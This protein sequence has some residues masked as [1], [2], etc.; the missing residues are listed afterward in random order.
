VQPDSSTIIVADW[1][2]RD[3]ILYRNELND[4]PEGV[5]SH[6]YCTSFGAACAYC[7]SHGYPLNDNGSVACFVSFDGQNADNVVDG[8]IIRR[9]SSAMNVCG[10]YVMP[11]FWIDVRNNSAEQMRGG[12]YG[13]TT[14]DQGPY[15]ALGAA[16]LG[17]RFFNNAFSANAAQ[18]CDF[19]WNN[20]A[21]V[22]RHGGNAAGNDMVCIAYER[23]TGTLCERGASLGRNANAVCR[24]NSF[25]LQNNP[26]VWG[27][28]RTGATINA[29]MRSVLIGN[30]YAGY[31]NKYSG[32]ASDLPLPVYRVARFVGNARQSLP[33]EVIPIANGGTADATWSVQSKSHSWITAT[34]ASTTV[35]PEQ[36]SGLL[37]VSVNTSTLPAG[38]TWGS[39]ILS[40]A[41]GKIA[42]V[43][44]RVEITVGP[45]KK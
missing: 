45:A 20:S 32:L 13:V 19:A 8:N 14:W 42:I 44:V 7:S 39:V 9:S 35:T 34:T 24:N 16:N 4:F 36:E 30:A 27:D 37:T 21:T 17:I 6:F 15:H 38:T 3:I 41:T 12:G 31:L 2:N 18:Q 43:T 22:L 10:S 28:H 23:N 33:A 5:R 26:K 25:S 40:S 29:N 11:T 1:V